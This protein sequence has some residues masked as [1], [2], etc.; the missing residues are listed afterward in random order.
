MRV[1]GDDLE[2]CWCRWGRVS[3]L[4]P[5]EE[6]IDIFSVNM[7]ATDEGPLGEGGQGTEWRVACGWTEWGTDA[8]PDAPAQV[9]REE[10]LI[11]VQRKVGLGN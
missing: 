2:G 5:A 9:R 11:R 7:E 1:A 6:S 4:C 10:C 8:E 3:G